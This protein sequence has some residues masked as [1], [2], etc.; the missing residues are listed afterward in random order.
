MS[1]N[2]A[3]TRANLIDPMLHIAGWGRT[4]V[5]REHYYRS[6]YAYTAGRVVLRGD[7]AE[8]EPHRLVDYIL[9]Y[10]DSFPIAV[11]EAKEKKSP[12]IQFALIEWAYKQQAHI[13]RMRD[14]A[15]ELSDRVRIQQ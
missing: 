2:E 1:Y 3:D 13:E 10:N 4:Q 11:V 7:Q 8:R 12:P 15:Q 9:R 14:K 6:D 5:T